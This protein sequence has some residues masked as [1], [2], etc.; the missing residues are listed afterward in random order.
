[1]PSG[2]SPDARPSRD[3][4]KRLGASQTGTVVPMFYVHDHGTVPGRPAPRGT[5]PAARG[6]G[7][8]RPSAGW[9][10]AIGFGATARLGIGQPGTG[11][12]AVDFVWLDPVSNRF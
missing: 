12:P 2:Q 6:D 5:G 1:M 4:P 8:G 7:V 9:Y 11:A 10:Y 3:V